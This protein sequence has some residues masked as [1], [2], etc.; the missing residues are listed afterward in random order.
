VLQ[1]RAAALSRAAQAAEAGERP[2]ALS[3]PR[4]AGDQ[5]QPRRCSDRGTGPSAPCPGRA[6]LR[7]GEATH[8]GRRRGGERERSRTSSSD[9]LAVADHDPGARGRGE[10]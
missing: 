10:R 8:Q 9:G 6:L 5:A 4:R 7:P 2:R 1:R 3:R